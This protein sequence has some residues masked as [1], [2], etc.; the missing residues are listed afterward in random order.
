M[1]SRSPENNYLQQGYFMYAGA[2]S[3]C[4]AWELPCI[5]AGSEGRQGHP[6]PL[7]R[8]EGCP[9]LRGHND[10]RRTPGLSACPALGCQHGSCTSPRT[11]GW[12]VLRNSLPQCSAN[13][14]ESVHG[15]SSPLPKGL[16]VAPTSD[17]WPSCA[18]RCRALPAC[19]PLHHAPNL[20]TLDSH[21]R[22]GTVTLTQP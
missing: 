11:R 20:S 2:C 7:S 16:Q 13:A 15:P 5:G 17:P 19:H 3:A 21:A 14:R 10:H 4:G 9:P 22:R 12:G 8:G 1:S 6:S 18:W